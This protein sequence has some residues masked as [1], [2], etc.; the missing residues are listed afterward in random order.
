[1]TAHGA[2]ARRAR[3]YGGPNSAVDF[4]EL[5][6]ATGTTEVPIPAR[7]RSCYWAVLR[8]LYTN[9][10]RDIKAAVLCEGARDILMERDPLAWARFERRSRPSQPDW[11][12]RL[13]TNARN[14]CRVRG[15]GAYGRRL[16]E[17]G[18]VLQCTTRD[19]CL[20]FRLSTDAHCV[21]L[22]PKKRGRKKQSGDGAKSGG[23][24]TMT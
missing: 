5:V 10:D 22:T 6:T 23:A 2:S 14:L 17:M 15:I 18:H 11:R 7:Y 3:N 9:P 1:M 13:T 16:L 21:D 8:Y 12:A 24:K 20:W 4:V 19:G